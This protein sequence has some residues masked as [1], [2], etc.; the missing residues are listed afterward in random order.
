MKTYIEKK[1]SVSPPFK[2]LVLVSPPFAFYHRPSIQLGALKAYITSQFRGIQVRAYHCHL[3][4]AQGIGYSVYQAI[5]ERTW[6]AETLYAAILF[7]EKLG[8]IE[9]VFRRNAR[10]SRFLNRDPFLTL[11]NQVKDVSE[12]LISR[13]SWNSF[14]LAGFSVSL[15]QL[16]ASLYFIRKVKQIAPEIHILVGGST[17]SGMDP[18]QLFEWFPEI[19]AVVC[20]EGE[21]PLSKVVSARIRGESEP[22]KMSIPGVVW[23]NGIGTQNSVSFHQIPN[24]EVIPPPDYDDYFMILKSAPPEKRF[25]PV[26]PLEMSRGCW[27]KK[28]SPSGKSRGCSFC[29]LNL[30][31]SGYRSKHPYQV[32]SEI[33]RITG[34]Y[35]ILSVAFTD[36]V[37]PKKI[38][39]NVF[40]EISK[41]GKDFQLF[42]ELRAD[43]SFEELKEMKKAGL[44][45]VQAGIESLSTSLLQRIHKGTSAIQNL[46]F[47][48]N[49]EALGIQN[50]SN[51]IL[52]FP[53]SSDTEVKETL[54]SLEYAFPFH[55]LKGVA[56]WLGVESPVWA[57]PKSYGIQRVFN[58]PNYRW[59]FPRGFADGC[60]MMIQAYR[61][62]LKEQ[63]RKWAPVR[64]RLAEW[65]SA[66]GRLNEKFPRRPILSYRDGKEFILIEERRLNAP[67]VRHRLTGTSRSIY[68]FCQSRRSIQDILTRFDK[69]T[70]DKVNPFLRMMVHKKLMFQEK[71]L[72]LSLAVPLNAGR[73]SLL[74]DG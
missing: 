69:M 12:N 5:S 35:Q 60:S 34:K 50:R 15:C 39:G 73:G 24:L 37:I 65:K 59:I 67:P 46:E 48:K 20:G 49:C 27:W 28:R 14:G 41:L 25:F 53:G 8:E 9:S 43:A 30:Q 40:K 42:C 21:L 22:E 32:I 7:P 3:S 33:D 10:G 11:V 36:N 19:D 74:R 54:F 1:R 16:S 31:W 70:T 52:Y 17:V 58:H 62:D 64:R 38:S 44:S 47:M 2:G 23:R 13:I 4:V 57:D 55:P 61:G 29:N 63:R 66:Y 71:E 18:G 6:L 51:L 45:E 72:Y 56:F 68:L 26:I